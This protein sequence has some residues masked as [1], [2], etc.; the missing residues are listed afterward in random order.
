MII[1]RISKQ[2]I[3]GVMEKKDQPEWMTDGDQSTTRQTA[4][5]ERSSVRPCS[6]IVLIWT[7]M[8]EIGNLIIG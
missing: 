7:E 2:H 8:G 5:N 1:R 4:E 3:G 6:I